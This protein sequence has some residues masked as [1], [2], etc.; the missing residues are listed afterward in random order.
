MFTG[1]PTTIANATNTVALWPGTVASTGAYRKALDWPLVRRMMPL[2]IITVA[3]SLVGAVLLMKTHP[4]T[5]DRLV[6][7]LLFAGTLFFNCRERIT[8]WV[9]R[10]IE[11]RFPSVWKAAW[12]TLVQGILAV[13]LGYFGAG[14]G[15]VMLPLISLMGV[16]NIFSLAGMRTLLVT[17]GNAVAVAVF[18]V[19][20]LVFWPKALVMMVGAILGGYAGAWY[21]QK[22]SPKTI[23]RVVIAIGYAMAVYFFWRTYLRG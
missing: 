16:S 12:L 7:W 2:I 10:H 14:V 9:A 1:L 8:G 18:I 11:T 19:A 5:F 20:H 21:A 6:P 4:T 23:S 17:C 15:I 22:L 13:Y 3:G